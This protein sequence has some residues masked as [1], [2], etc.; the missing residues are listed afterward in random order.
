MWQLVLAL[1]CVAVGV[2]VGVTGFSLHSEASELLLEVS[3]MYSKLRQAV[4][5]D[6]ECTRTSAPYEKGSRAASM[7]RRATASEANLV[8]RAGIEPDEE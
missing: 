4:A 5:V 3:M 2:G 1:A 8:S 7:C 6:E